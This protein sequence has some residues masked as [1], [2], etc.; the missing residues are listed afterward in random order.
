MAGL[1]TGCASA[2]KQ[3]H[4][5]M[6]ATEAVEK[7]R[8]GVHDRDSVASLL[9]SPVNKAGFK[10][11][12]WLYVSRQSERLAFFEEKIQDQ[13]V[14]ALRFDEDGILRDVSRYNL[15][16]GKVIVPVERVTPT[17]GNELTVLQQLF[18]NIGRFTGNDKSEPGE[19]R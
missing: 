17:R 5:Y 7:L 4:G 16:D 6:P 18:G 14:L 1:L 11:Q 12:T 10:D 2:I 15:K 9:G 19:F 3:S 13:S 8:P